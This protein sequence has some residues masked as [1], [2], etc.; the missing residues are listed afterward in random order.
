[1]GTSEQVP[2]S[3][4]GEQSDDEYF[5]QDPNA[6]RFRQLAHSLLREPGATKEDVRKAIK[7]YGVD[8]TVLDRIFRTK[9]HS[10]QVSQQQ[11][12]QQAQGNPIYAEENRKREN[13]VREAAL[14]L[15]EIR[16][17]GNKGTQFLRDLKKQN[18]SPE[19]IAQVDTAAGAPAQKRSR[20]SRKTENQTPT[21]QEVQKEN[22][23]AVQQNIIWIQQQREKKVSEPDIV[24]TLRD[25][26]WEE[27]EI[28]EQL[29]AVNF[30]SPDSQQ[31]AIHEPHKQL[32]DQSSAVSLDLEGTT[33]SPATSSDAMTSIEGTLSKE[34]LAA[35]RVERLKEKKEQE[36]IL[37]N[38][39]WILRERKKE[40]TR[41]EELTRRLKK[42]NL[43][44]E[45][46]DKTFKAANTIASEI[47]AKEKGRKAA[48]ILRDSLK[49]RAQEEAVIAPAPIESGSTSAVVPPEDTAPAEPPHTPSADTSTIADVPDTGTTEGMGADVDTSDVINPF[50][51]QKGMQ[52]EMDALLSKTGEAPILDAAAQPEPEQEAA[53]D[54]LNTPPAPPIEAETSTRS[55]E[56][57]LEAH[58]AAPEEE[59][60]PRRT[61]ETGT[62]K[63]WG[64]F[65]D[66]DYTDMPSKAEG[67]PKEWREK[68]RSLI[69]GAKDKIGTAKEKVDWWKSSEEHLIRRSAELD[70]EAE[71]IGGIEKT[72]RSWGESYNKMNWKTKLA[73][74]AGLGLGAAFTAGSLAIAIPLL[75]IG[76]QRTLGLSTMYLKFEK[77]SHDEAWGKEKALLKAGVYTVLMGLAMKE[78]IEYVSE[79]ELAHTMQAKVS[80][81]LGDMLGHHT[82][83]GATPSQEIQSTDAMGNQTGQVAHTPEA[84]P[85]VSEHLAAAAAADEAA[86]SAGAPEI[87][88]IEVK[89]SS[90]HGYEYMTKRLWEQ[91]QEK[92]I[93]LPPGANPDSDLAKLLAADKSSIDKVVHQLAQDNEFFKENGTSAIVG[94]HA[95]MTIDAK[96][97]IWLGEDILAPKGGSITPA[98]HPEVPAADISVTEEPVVPLPAETPFF[99]PDAPIVQAD[100][101]VT[102]AGPAPFESGWPESNGAH[103]ISEA[104]GVH[105]PIESHSVVNSF[106]I[107]VSNTEPHVYVNGKD[108]FVYGGSSAQKE[109]MILDYLTK[110]PTQTVMSGDDV[111][112]YRVPWHLVEGKLVP[113]EPL[114]KTGFLGLTK[115]FVPPPGPGEFKE[116][117]Y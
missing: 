39:Y 84:A 4:R 80:N 43:T 22:A 105:S 32:V 61:P 3:G 58:T 67:T 90:G 82:T 5:E 49:K 24:N 65:E 72:F 85:V 41:D 16:E 37:D 101:P 18:F 115:S 81:W 78:A 23:E 40:G 108:L 56:E 70:A 89:A 114:T 86:K 62:H 8:D 53:A 76:I 109:R 44:Q 103:P 46:I 27:E 45:F 98:Y 63:K 50:K 117:V 52:E 14:K 7:E 1:M 83:P 2:R 30:S 29:K 96:G 68:L 6:A 87:P 91:L 10:D 20:G 38:A 69:E 26:G 106:G 34:Q 111:G 48:K 31:Q 60:P 57:E 11:Q 97:N 77:N 73:L 107:E 17:R 71:K 55:H 95:K 116:V 15:A 64:E 51:R 102:E 75:G 36:A 13:E 25:N 9:E 113:G 104:S 110:N 33:S 94:E 79:T 66:I 99:H 19:E 74:S 35:Q 54:A 47:D 21:E 88:G 112:K 100:V 42:A 59:N 93:K 28:L 92:H 12:Q